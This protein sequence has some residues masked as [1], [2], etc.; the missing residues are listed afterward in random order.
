MIWYEL[1]VY[2]FCRS[3][4]STSLRWAERSTINRQITSHQDIQSK[5]LKNVNYL[6]NYLIVSV[7]TTH[8]IHYA[9]KNNTSNT[10]VKIT[11]QSL[12]NTPKNIYEERQASHEGMEYLSNP[13]RRN[14]YPSSPVDAVDTSDCSFLSLKNQNTTNENNTGGVC[15]ITTRQKAG[16]NPSD[17]PEVRRF[18]LGPLLTLS[19]PSCYNEARSEL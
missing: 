13:Q 15:E 14:L 17:H 7:R 19:R 4:L 16:E 11:L 1:T 6:R 10:N 3:Y 5:R 9:P 12:I 8:A 18:F 2:V